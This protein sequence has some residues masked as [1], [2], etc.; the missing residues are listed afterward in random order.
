MGFFV[1]VLIYAQTFSLI[2]EPMLSASGGKM[3]LSSLLGLPYGV[4]VLLVV[5]VAFATFYLLG[6]FEGRLYSKQATDSAS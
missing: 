4:V 5:I 3:T 6:K 1:G 2:F